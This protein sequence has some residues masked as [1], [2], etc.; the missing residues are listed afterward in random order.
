M[1]ERKY[2]IDQ[3]SNFAKNHSLLG[4]KSLLT[5][6]DAIQIAETENSMYHQYKFVNNQPMLR[7]IIEVKHKASDYIR[8]QILKQERTNCQTQLLLS[9]VNELNGYR[10]DS[11]AVEA[12]FYL[13]IQTD[14]I[15][16]YYVYDITGNHTNVNYE[17]K[18]KVT[19]TDDYVKMFQ[20]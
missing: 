4:A 12:E 3:Q 8:K 7:R 11:N 1:R 20:F 6:V 14:G 16:P 17:Y 2:N 9:V 15:L 19:N 18:G 13:I 10:K 5:D